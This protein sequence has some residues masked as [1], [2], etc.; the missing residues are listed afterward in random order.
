MIR[1]KLLNLGL[2]VLT[3][4]NRRREHN[5]GTGAGRAG[6]GPVLPGQHHAGGARRR[7]IIPADHKWFRDLAISQI[8][9]ET[10]E[11]LKMELPEPTVN[12]P[13]I[14]QQ[15]HVA[16]AEEKKAGYANVAVPRTPSDVDKS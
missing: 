13:Q 2:A 4:R 8:I 11:S 15:Y 16:V 3:V 12:L 9:A 10:L 14:R 5:G 7:F 6:S 1:N